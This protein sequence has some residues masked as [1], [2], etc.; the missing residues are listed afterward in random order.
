MTPGVS[1]CHNNTINPRNVKF[2]FYG[3]PVVLERAVRCE[4]RLPTKHANA[5][6]FCEAQRVFLAWI[7]ATPLAIGVR[8][9]QRLNLILLQIVR[10]DVL[11]EPHCSDKQTLAEAIQGILGAG[12]PTLVSVE[13]ERHSALW[14]NSIDDQLFL[15]I[16]ERTP[17]DRHSMTDTIL[18]ESHHIEIPLY[19]HQAMLVC[20]VLGTM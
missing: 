3:L 2:A 1:Y 9:E 18:V 16:T 20:T 12:L 19:N 14:S 15:G 13:A 8:A 11:V 5:L 17:H 6:A 10:L 4:C 7:C